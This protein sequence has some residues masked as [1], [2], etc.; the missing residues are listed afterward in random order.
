MG[1]R[2]AR[3]HLAAYAD[4]GGGLDAAERRALVTAT[5]LRGER[6]PLAG[7]QRRGRAA[8]EPGGDRP[9]EPGPADRR[10]RGPPR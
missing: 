5:E 2:H 8:G 10:P 7:R 9:D 6:R 4:H 3:K 1:V